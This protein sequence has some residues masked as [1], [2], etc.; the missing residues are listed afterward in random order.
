MRILILAN[1]AVGLYQFRSELIEE[2]LINNTVY[3]SSPN[4]EMIR[5]LEK[6]GCE[7]IETSIDRRG[8]NPK[9]DLKLL[10]KYICIVKELK[11]DLVITYTVKPNIYGGLACSLLK[12]KYAVNITGLGT[13][14]EKQGLLR[15]I[16]V[17][18]YKLSSRN[19][20]IVFFENEENRQ[21]FISEGIV[22][23][24][25]THR[26]NGA[27][28]N[29]DKYQ[30]SEYP[31]GEITKF[32]FMGRIMAEK[33]IDELLNSM[34]RLIADGEK[35]ELHVV[36]TF[37][38]DYKYLIEKYQKEG[39]LIYHGYQKDVRPFI[40]ESHCFVLP[41]WH[42]GM[43][44]TN[45]ESAASGRPVITT[46]IHGCLEAV[47]DGKTGYLVEKKNSDDL[48]KTMKKFIRLPYETK[49]EM[50]L[51]GREHMEN[52]FDKKKVIE[53][54]LKGLGVH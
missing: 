12:T 53:D 33:G 10:K 27:G 25:K 47:I 31:D 17:T 42:E 24:E 2:L 43:A 37:E 28:V 13:A 51:K 52:V 15:K 3:I 4:G 21:I 39:W 7:Y 14:F 1:D 48:Y 29:L 35:C 49:R 9:T 5:K 54:T 46:N 40:K 18:L 38:E 11:P 41:S 16:V 44:N 50:G 34:K 36:G 22:K 8:I 6:M 32:L 23:E 26:L 30:L 20:K 45:L 19:A